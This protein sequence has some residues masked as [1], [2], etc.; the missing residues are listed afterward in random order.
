[1]YGSDWPV[2]TLAAGYKQWVEVLQ[3]ATAALPE[4]ARFKLFSENAR[5]FYRL[6]ATDECLM[7]CRPASLPPS[8]AGCRPRSIMAS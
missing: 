5:T 6:P 3:A 4:A 1:M 8:R 2:M 7:I